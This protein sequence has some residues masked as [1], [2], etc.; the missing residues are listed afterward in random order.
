M[1]LDEVWKKVGLELGLNVWNDWYPYHDCVMW[2]SES[3]DAA[4]G[5]SGAGVCSVTLHGVYIPACLPMNFV[6]MQAHPGDSSHTTPPVHTARLW[7]NW[8]LC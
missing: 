4:T 3:W 1:Q 5:A 6:P 8:G 7:N 2:G